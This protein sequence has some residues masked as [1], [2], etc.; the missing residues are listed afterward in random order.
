VRAA[1][2]LLFEPLESR[3]AARVVLLLQR[4]LLDLELASATCELVE[5]DGERVDLHAQARGGLVDQVDRLVGQLAIGDVAARQHRR[6]NQR[7]VLDANAVVHLVALLESAQDRDRVLDRRLVDEHRLEAP[8]K[9]RILLDVLAIFIE[10]GRAD[11]VQLA[12]RERR[13]Q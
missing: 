10:R 6:R 7:C 8:L 11:A 1:S 3:A 12:A 5:L 2:Q 13:L 9:R 4:L